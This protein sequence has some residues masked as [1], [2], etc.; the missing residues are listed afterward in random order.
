M[1]N[2]RIVFIYIY[3][4]V[5]SF[6]LHVWPWSLVLILLLL[7][8]LLFYYKYLNKKI[9]SKNCACLKLC[10][11]QFKKFKIN[12][13]W[14]DKV[15]FFKKKKFTIYTNSFHFVSLGFSSRIL[16]IF[17][18]IKNYLKKANYFSRTDWE[19]KLI[20]IWFSNSILEMAWKSDHG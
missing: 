1:L 7:S 2:G 15:D 3:N 13:V 11:N 16:T 6:S 8:L 17:L 5:N 18:R 14:F 19:N 10:K 12:F 9:Q 4:T 20:G